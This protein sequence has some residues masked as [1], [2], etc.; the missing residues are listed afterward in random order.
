MLNFNRTLS[1][2]KKVGILIIVLNL[3]GVIG[4]MTSSWISNSIQGSARAIDQIG[5]MRMKSYQLLSL[6]P[7]NNE[8]KMALSH[9]P[10][11]NE[12]LHKGNV[13]KNKKEDANLLDRI[14]ER[15][16]LTS[17][18]TDLQ[19]H[20]ETQVK[21]ALLSA[22]TINDARADVDIFV[23]KLDSLVKK[24]D[25]QTEQ[26][27]KLSSR[28]HSIF[29][30]LSIVLTIIGVWFLRLRIFKPWKEL[31]KI[32]NNI[33][34][35]DFS[36]RFKNNKFQDE[37]SILG[38]TMNSMSAQLGRMYDELELRVQQKTLYIREQNLWLSFLYR[39]STQLH[40]SQSTCL[41]FLP[42]LKELETLTPLTSLQLNLYENNNDELF[43]QLNTFNSCR[44]DHCTNHQCG[45]CLEP[46]YNHQTIGKNKLEWPLRDLHGEYGVMIAYCD[47]EE[48]L[49]TL[50]F[51]LVQTLVDQLST[52]L[53]LEQQEYKN[54]QL[55]LM[56][57]RTVIARELHDS[58]A[59]SLS[60][61]KIK[62]S[63][64]QMQST[65]LT[66]DQVELVKEMR[67]ELNSAYSQLR[68]LLTT[69]RLKLNEPGLL[70]AL[71]LTI[72]EFNKK[73]GFN[74]DLDYSLPPKCVSSH[75]AIHLVQI[76]REAL[77][78][79][80]KHANANKAS[81][82]LSFEPLEKNVQVV[83]RDNGKGL[84]EN[85]NRLNHYGL[86]IMNDRASNLPG[87]CSVLNHPNGGVEVKIVFNSSQISSV[88]K[89]E[90]YA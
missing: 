63:C 14:L 86:T 88:V 5:A 58:I 75:Q 73:L 7:L 53:A 87:Q 37:M 44:P 79:I 59:Q 18:Y 81:I 54:Q 43:E 46:K 40:S 39:A 2:V 45:L 80:Y 31:L 28:F 16:N 15:D 60:C 23:G 20:W 19:H 27:L 21:P 35:G 64:L 76:I 68:E 6:I 89:G 30:F 34:S 50:Q 48:S 83:I 57:E 90:H 61:L 70:P 38:E 69:F 25:N 62:I 10:Y 26:K 72:D 13:Q 71:E 67:L 84:G 3:F 47:P 77:S 29:T 22:E 49:T 11:T 51:R 41:R 74:I 78:N 17:E 32:A 42:I 55:M 56:K 65:N 85:T 52:A 9:F 24:I 8:D 33:S 82:Q 1:I 4:M 66:T 12:L 36:H